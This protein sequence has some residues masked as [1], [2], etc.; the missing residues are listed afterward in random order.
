MKS[1]RRDSKG[2]AS[3]AAGASRRLP[4]HHLPRDFFVDL[5][6]HRRDVD[7]FFLGHWIVAGHVASVPREGDY[8]L[9]DIGF[10]SI[11]I[12]RGTDGE[13]HAAM[14]VCRHRGSRVAIEEYGHCQ[15][16]VCPMHGWAYAHDG[17]L[18]AAP[19][20]SETFDKSRHGL[21]V[22]GVEV[23]DGVI[24]LCLDQPADFSPLRRDM[25]AFCAGYDLSATRIAYHRRYLCPANWKLVVETFLELQSSGA[26]YPEMREV[27]AKAEA[28]ATRDRGAEQDYRDYAAKWRTDAESRNSPADI[29]RRGELDYTCRR[30]PIR[31]GFA[32]Q[33]KD[34]TA[35]APLLGTLDSSDGGVTVVRVLSSWIIICSDY[36]AIVRLT[37]LEAQVT[38]MDVTWLV[39]KSAV[40]G[41]DY[42]A[43]RLSWLWRANVER[44]LKLASDNQLGVS[45]T[46]YEP[47]PFAPDEAELDAWVSWYLAQFV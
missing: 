22:F 9:Y 14:N 26:A 1:A 34:G 39:R 4:G 41:V 43:P 28:A 31:H 10:E 36:A 37:R 7:R 17:T 20:M 15:H 13:V 12:S 19:N 33:S 8:F 3:W 2:A 18:L 40:E 25:H 21:K 24:F 27:M 45:S 47:G 6:V 42:D 5:E 32:T 29:A 44:A 35:V 11:V 46:R 16:F 23:V 38:E 30:E